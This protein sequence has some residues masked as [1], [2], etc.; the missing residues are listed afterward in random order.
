MFLPLLEGLEDGAGEAE[1][2]KIKAT[3]LHTFI[4]VVMSPY[5]RA[6]CVVVRWNF[7]RRIH[8][9]GTG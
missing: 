1:M 5:F 7:A 9:Y 8:E 3:F 2:A 4:G 6:R